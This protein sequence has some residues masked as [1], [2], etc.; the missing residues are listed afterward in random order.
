MIMKNKIKFIHITKTA[1]TSIEDV[2]L[3]HGF[4]WGRHD[5]SLDIMPL[6]GYAPWHIPPRFYK[7]KNPYTGKIT[8]AVVRNPYDRIL[9]EVFFMNKMIHN[10]FELDINEFNDYI[11]KHLDLAENKLQ[12]HFLPQHYYTHNNGEKDVTHILKF[13]NV[14]E[15]FNIMMNKYKYNIKLDVFANETNK[16]RTIDDITPENI[17]RINDVYNLDFSYFGYPKIL[18]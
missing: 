5:K 3:K 2:G 9:S 13:D 1:G 8:F 12:D 15:E 6:E 18:E 11:S 16:N 10:K 14:V 4:K 7:K 17:K